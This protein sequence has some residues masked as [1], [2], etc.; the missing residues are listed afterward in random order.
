[1]PKYKVWVEVEQDPQRGYVVT[2]DAAKEMAEEVF[3]EDYGAFTW[4]EPDL[5]KMD[6]AKAAQVV[7]LKE[8][9]E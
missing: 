2:E 4:D 9:T 3:D 8:G 5:T 6:I 1:M 7:A